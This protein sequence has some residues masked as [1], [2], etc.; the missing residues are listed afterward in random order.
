MDEIQLLTKVK[1]TF[2]F[3]MIYLRPMSPRLFALNLQ[4]K[5]LFISKR[6]SESHTT[7]SEISFAAIP[8]IEKIKLQLNKP[9]DDS[10]K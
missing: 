3:G 8:T 10:D 7:S 1:V 4:S 6:I 9:E 5:M 2:I